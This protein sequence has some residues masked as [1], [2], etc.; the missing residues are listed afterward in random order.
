MTG[1]VQRWVRSGT[2]AATS[3]IGAQAGRGAIRAGWVAGLLTCWPLRVTSPGDQRGA[4]E[5]LRAQHSARHLRTPAAPP[6]LQP[7]I[8]M[9]GGGAT[10]VD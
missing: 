5:Y 6:V 7:V 2:S 8:V 1:G 4:T 10:G 9:I 3:G